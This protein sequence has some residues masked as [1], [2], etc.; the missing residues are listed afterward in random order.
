MNKTL[1]SASALLLV[2]TSCS[3]L[4]R[5]NQGAEAPQET[6]A[7]KIE[8]L[9]KQNAELSTA[10]TSLSSKLQTVETRLASVSDKLEAS[11][12][13]M[14]NVIENTRA[15]PAPVKTIPT[16]SAEQLPPAG[17]DDAEAAFT[18]NEPVRKYRQAMILFQS[19]NYPDASL[20]FS[21][22][23]DQFPD[24]TLAGSAQFYLGE[25]YFKQGEYKLAAREL[26]R[27]ITTYDRSPH[28]AETLRDL[29]T[30]EEKTG[31]AEEA[32]RHRHLL[33]S[34][35][36][37]SPAAHSATEPESAPASEPASGESQ[38][39]SVPATTEPAHAAP[40]T[41]NVTPSAEAT[42]APAPNAPALDAPPPTAPMAP[43]GPAES[44]TR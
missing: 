7:Q 40:P 17:D 18:A 2:C 9:Q 5:R 12:R 11:T 34:L 15:K 37:H 8:R 4:S 1:I 39:D 3:S 10:L 23:V 16:E 30:A 20:G 44:E 6:E 13:R 41:A 25:S 32:A 14:D 29:A 26:S 38:L 36:P 24:H 22:F 19:H 33:T 43:S 31:Q 27:V 42:T 21:A 35:F 28:I